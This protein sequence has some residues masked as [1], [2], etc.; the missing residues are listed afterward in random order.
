MYYDVESCRLDLQ[1][2]K[3]DTPLHTAARWGYEGIIQV[4]LENGASTD[5]LNK[6]KESPLQCALNSKV[7]A[8]PKCC[9]EK[10][11]NLQHDHDLTWEC[12]NALQISL[13]FSWF[14][15]SDLRCE[16]FKALQTSRISGVQLISPADQ[17]VFDPPGRG[18]TADP[19][20]LD[21]FQSE[22]DSRSATRI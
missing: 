1:N 11:Q 22:S 9:V 10:Y 6:S 21:A 4:L 17:K 5:I 19:L 15:F 14:L 13:L 7:G 20:S 16:T 12:V 8:E 2:D 3:G 18:N